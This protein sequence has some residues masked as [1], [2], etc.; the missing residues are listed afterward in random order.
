MAIWVDGE[1]IPNDAVDYELDRL[2]KFYSQHMS[3]EEIRDQMPALREKARGQAIGAKLL[4]GEARRLDLRVPPG[5]V[6]S[7]LALMV[8]GAGGP[9]RFRNLL[10][11]QGMDEE[12]VR[13]SIEEGRR[14]DLLIERITAGI[15]DPT[16]EELR[17]HFQEHEAEYATSD[18][19]Q[20]QHILIKPDSDDGA[21]R[22]TA[23]STL[24]GIRCRIE[25]GAEFAGEAAAHSQCPSGRK[26]GGSLGWLSRGMAI[27]EIEKASFSLALNEVS[28]VVETH[29]GFHI[30]RKTAEEAGG[31][32]NYADVADTI[33]EF[34]RHVRR[35]EAIAAHV[36]E[37]RAK[38]TIE[39]D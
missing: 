27:P 3:T 8:Q 39:E 22:E 11:R 20:I 7:R 26:T 33:R 36:A 10:E 34:L 38:A 14:V 2:V 31:P 35:G 17:A 4:I 30:F 28:D 12:T 24:L 15:S 5:E 1:P 21:D 6:D 37:L 19:A 9:E 16:E 13:R 32:A 25:D 23:R 18:R 29:L